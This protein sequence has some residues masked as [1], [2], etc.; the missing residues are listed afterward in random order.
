MA[1]RSL[2]SSTAGPA[3]G[4][5]MKLHLAATTGVVLGT[6]MLSLSAAPVMTWYELNSRS[7]ELR[8]ATEK[9]ATSGVQT[10][11]FLIAIYARR[12]VHF[13]NPICVRVV[14]SR[15]VQLVDANRKEWTDLQVFTAVPLTIDELYSTISTIVHDRPKRLRIE[16]D[17]ILGY[18]SD[19]T[20]DYSDWTHDEYSYEIS[21]LRTFENDANQITAPSGG[22]LS[23]LLQ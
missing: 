10:Y 15:P 9:W 20:V 19:V 18:P 6:G 23:R 4:H 14:N 3:F 11:E 7:D 8:A 1:E 21:W 12:T 13:K 5:P 16:Y 17:P 22:C 2:L